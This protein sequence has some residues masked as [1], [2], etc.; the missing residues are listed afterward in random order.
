MT[1]LRGQSGA[2]GASSAGTFVILSA[3][4][5]R[6]DLARDSREQEHWEAHAGFI[7]RLVAEGFI[8]LGGPLVDEGGALLIVSAR[9]EAEA[10][11]RIRD[12]PWY[13]H[14]LLTLVGVK[15]WQIFIDEW[16]P[17]REA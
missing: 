7:D 17:A 1:A 16:R 10:R 11:E 2:R 14:G 12:D 8:L 13:I 4:G 15:R 5:P 6:R 9:D 3:A